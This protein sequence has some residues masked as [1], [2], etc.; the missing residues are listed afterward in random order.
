M[1]TREDFRFPLFVR[2][3]LLAALM[4]LIGATACRGKRAGSGVAVYPDW[5]G[6][7]EVPV[8]ADLAAALVTCEPAPLVCAGLVSDVLL[9]MR[10]PGRGV[11][12]LK[13]QGPL[14]LT[15]PD[16]SVHHVLFREHA[17]R[18]LGGER[19]ASLL[20]VHMEPGRDGE[21]TV[22]AVGRGLVGGKNGVLKCPKSETSFR[23]RKDGS[24]WSCMP[25]HP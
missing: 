4:G 19:E 23:I 12:V 9:T 16:S 7:G 11:V 13:L 8:E 21:A 10:S 1:L 25:R 17:V 24:K 5:L 6:T 18:F 22:L 2:S 3:L 15:R 20:H 14:Q